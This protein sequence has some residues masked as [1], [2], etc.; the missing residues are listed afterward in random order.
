MGLTK[1]VRGTST[2]G[3]IFDNVNGLIDLAETSIQQRF[4]NHFAN[5]DKM[6]YIVSGDSTR[7]NASNYMISYYTKQLSK[8]NVNVINDSRSGASPKNWFQ[9]LWGSVSGVQ[10][11]IDS[12][13]GTGETTIL[14][15]SF[16]LNGDGTG[17]RDADIITGL[18]M[19][20]AAK[21]DALIILVS[22]VG[23]WVD[24]TQTRAEYEAIASILGIPVLHASYATD[25]I[26]Q[27]SDFMTDGTHPN[28]YGS[29]RVVNWLMSEI[30]PD[31]CRIAMDLEDAEKLPLPP[32]N[33]VI[34]VVN[35]SYYTDYV[36]TTTRRALAKIDVEPNFNLR[37]KH[38]GDANVIVYYDQNSVFISRAVISPDA[39]G[40]YNVV[41]PQGCYKV[42]IN[43]VSADGATWDALGFRPI[44]EY[45]VSPIPWA[46]QKRLNAGIS[47][48]LPYTVN[49]FLD[50][51]G[52]LP[53][54]GEKPT[55]VVG[56]QWVWS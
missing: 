34:T 14:E 32:N 1:L 53:G 56:G 50:K 35:G 17:T 54:V 31:K 19:Y 6:T 10:H 18:Q 22:P 26:R 33:F 15:Y 21:P 7:D 38:M 9:N 39:N 27:N 20:M 12:T 44:V 43:I 8:V 37:F 55:G 51:D 13:P 47:I 45:V 24:K 28:Q 4:L 52:K 5:R 30:L 2:A 42:G 16:G 23:G 41:I 49:P 40:Y 25:A 3:D 29:M 46:S 48:A 36:P 11:A